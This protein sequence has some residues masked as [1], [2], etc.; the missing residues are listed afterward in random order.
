MQYQCVIF[1]YQPLLF[2]SPGVSKENILVYVRGT[3]PG[4]KFVNAQQTIGILSI[5]GFE[6]KHSIGNTYTIQLKLGMSSFAQTIVTND[7]HFL[8]LEYIHLN[9]CLACRELTRVTLSV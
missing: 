2:R 8:I 5:C 1:W 9:I 3:T 4:H 7:I 6:V